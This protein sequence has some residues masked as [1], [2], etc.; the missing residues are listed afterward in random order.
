[1][2]NG[3]YF[4]QMT[5]MFTD[6]CVEICEFSENKKLNKEQK[7][8]G[9]DPSASQAQ[10]LGNPGNYRERRPFGLQQF[11]RERRKFFKDL[12]CHLFQSEFMLPSPIFS[13]SRIIY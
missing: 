9:C 13:R 7:V 6:L 10:R 5:R 12:G 3:Q 2:V 4:S 8:Q 11:F 1:M